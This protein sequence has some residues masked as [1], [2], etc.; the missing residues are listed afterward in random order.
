MYQAPAK[1]NQEVS[2]KTFFFLLHMQL[3][4]NDRT[5]GHF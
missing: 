2:K 3:M 5:G 1:V 4:S